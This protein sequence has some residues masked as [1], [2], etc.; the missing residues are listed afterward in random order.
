MTLSKFLKYTLLVLLIILHGETFAQPGPPP[1]PN[2]PITGIEYLIGL[3]GLLGIR[4]M[5][6]SFHKRPKQ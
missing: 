6:K 3:G 4:K 2:S 5:V 1:D